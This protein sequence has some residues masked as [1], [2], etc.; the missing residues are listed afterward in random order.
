MR[1]SKPTSK[2]PALP[3]FD[4][5]YR[6][7]CELGSG[8]TATV[9]LAHDARQDRKVAIKALKPELSIA[10]GVARF[11]REIRLMARLTHPNILPLLDSGQSNGVMYYVMPYVQG[12]SLRDRLSREGPLPIRDAVQIA[13]ETADALA[14]A[15]MQGIVH[16]DIKPDNLLLVAGHAVIADFGIAFAQFGTDIELTVSGRTVGTPAYMSPEQAAGEQ[17]DA[18]TDIYSLGC[19]LFEMLTGHLPINGVDAATLMSRKLSTDALPVATFRRNVPSHVATATARALARNRAARFLTAADF[20]QALETAEVG[21][22]WIAPANEVSSVAVLPFTTRGGEPTDDF[23]GDGLS[24]ELI[25]TMSRLPGIRV[26]ARTSAFAFKNTTLDLKTIAERLNVQRIVEGVVRIAGPNLR[27]T[28]Q[29]IDPA[30]S[31]QIWSGRYDRLADDILAIQDEIA[32]AIATAIAPVLTP[33]Q[34]VTVQ[35]VE[36]LPAS[37]ETAAPPRTNMAAYE[38]YLRGRYVFA[39]RTEAGLRRCIELQQSAIARDPGFALAHAAL[40]DAWTTLGLYGMTSSDDAMPK[41]RVAADRALAID[42]SLGEALTARASVSAIH[43]HQWESAAADFERAIVVA[44]QYGLAYQWYAMNYF[45]PLARFTNAHESLQHA[46]LLDPLSQS[47]AVSSIAVDYY[48]RDHEAAVR[49]CVEAIRADDRFAMT[50]YFHGLALEQQNA[51]EKARLAL[52]R[53]AEL[54]PSAE[55]LTALARAR[56]RSGDATGARSLRDSLSVPSTERYVSPVL[57]AQLDLAF[58]EP[59]EALRHLAQARAQHA[60][61][62]IWI[63]VR[64]TFDPLRNDPRF[65]AHLDDLRLPNIQ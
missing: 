60:C 13:H 25:H 44:P 63:G 62:L 17:V 52:Q 35:S 15:H 28:A 42:R 43:D 58:E 36:T 37:A 33:S 40:A 59:E 26:I 48:A 61:D 50:H 47:L 30:T 34:P 53:A 18:R 6:V 56:L 14:Y 46:R 51:P 65:R 5:R 55:I 4:A 24:E 45:V 20:V 49:A 16:R 22:T 21:A 7:E 29:L 39:M 2:Y 11:Q 12:E 38:D 64:P 54:S 27:V 19:V 32:D 23:I 9:Y 57:V 8:G 41:A 10:M 31:F 1:P 3:H